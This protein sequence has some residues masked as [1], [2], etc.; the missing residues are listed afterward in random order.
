[1]RS[2]GPVFERVLGTEHPNT[3]TLRGNLAHFTGELDEKA[4]A[5][6]QYA[7]LLPIHERVLGAEHPLTLRSF[8]LAKWI[9]QANDAEAARD[10]FATLCRS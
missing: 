7:T 3:L 10:Q 6:D 8:N 4:E 5:R 9:G 2:T 1:V